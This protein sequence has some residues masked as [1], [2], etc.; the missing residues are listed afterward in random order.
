[1]IWANL[2][3]LWVSLILIFHLGKE[4]STLR[5]RYFFY[6]LIVLA[7]PLYLTHSFFWTEPFFTAVLL[8]AFFALQQFLK[9]NQILWLASSLL[10]FLLLPTIRLA[11]TFI[12]FPIFFWLLIFPSGK[13]RWMAAASCILLVGLFLLWIFNFSAILSQGSSL[14]CIDQFLGQLVQNLASFLEGFSIWFIPHPMPLLFRLV[15]GALVIGFLGFTAML[16]LREN[17]LDIYGIIATSFI[18]YYFALHP[19]FQV[20]FYTAER[21][22]A[23]M[24]ALVFLTLF[25]WIDDHHAGLNPW[26][27]KILLIV[28]ILQSIYSGL[29]VSNN[30]SLW[31]E[32]RCAENYSQLIESEK[33][34]FEKKYGKIKKET[35]D[36]PY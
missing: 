16:S 29:R 25:K 13:G 23:P 30:L 36:I 27:K 14:L 34:S 21:Y 6:A 12:S 9:T 4:I 8:V 17:P 11:G 35:L 10:A 24:F 33:V 15:A 3:C 28:L 7:T 5:L 31:S 26:A 1:M 32:V 19:Y 2:A 20:T 18:L 22:L